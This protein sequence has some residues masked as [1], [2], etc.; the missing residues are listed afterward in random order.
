MRGQGLAPMREGPGS[1][2]GAGYAPLPVGGHGRR[3]AE[4]DVDLAE[5]ERAQ[6]ALEHALGVLLRVLNE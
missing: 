3:G 5:A 4:C 1:G 6:Q 2:I